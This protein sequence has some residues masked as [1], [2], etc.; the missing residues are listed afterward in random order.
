MTEGL[1][2]DVDKKAESSASAMFNVYLL[3]FN[4]CT[5]LCDLHQGTITT[6]LQIHVKDKR[7]GQSD[8]K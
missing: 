3:C 6:T 5:F 4:H 7:P 8:V 2:A 1:S